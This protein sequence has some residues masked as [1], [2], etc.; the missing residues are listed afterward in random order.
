M[1]RVMKAPQPKWLG[2]VKGGKFWAKNPEAWVA[3]VKKHEQLDK[4]GEPR[5][6]EVILKWFYPKRSRRQNAYYWGVVVPIYAD[7]VGEEDPDDAHEDLK[8]EFSWSETFVDKQGREHRKIKSTAKMTTEEFSQYLERIWLWADKEG[9]RI[10][11]PNE[12]DIPDEDED[13]ADE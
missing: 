9:L 10:P 3:H 7:Y 4:E 6:V 2:V 12:V 13:G 1:V 5:L 8:A 11:R